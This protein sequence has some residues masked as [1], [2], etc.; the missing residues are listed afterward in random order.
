M[1]ASTVLR[2][3]GEKQWF[4]ASYRWAYDVKQTADRA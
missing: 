4:D 3:S 2:R 1:S